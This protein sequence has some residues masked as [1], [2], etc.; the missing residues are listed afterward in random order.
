MAYHDLVA[1]SR[2]PT[3][4]ITHGSIGIWKSWNL[5]VFIKAFL[6]YLNRG[7]SKRHWRIGQSAGHGSTVHR[8]TEEGKG[9][10]ESGENLTKHTW[11]MEEELGW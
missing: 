1:I 5:Q 8:S 2:I 10:K 3:E 6:F 9:E 4:K 11:E 7:N